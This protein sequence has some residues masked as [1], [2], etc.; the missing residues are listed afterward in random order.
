MTKSRRG[1]LVPRAL[2]KESLVRTRVME[3]TLAVQKKKTVTT[4]LV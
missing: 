1:L 2:Q 3:E 4:M